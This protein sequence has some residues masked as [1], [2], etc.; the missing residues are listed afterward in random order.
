MNHSIKFTKRRRSILRFLADY[1]QD[2]GFPPSIREVCA[3]EEISSSSTVW[4]HLDALEKLKYIERD[5]SKPRSVSVTKSGFKALG[6]SGR[7]EEATAD[8]RQSLIECMDLLMVVCDL[9]EGTPE[10]ALFDRAV[11]A[12]GGPEAWNAAQEELARKREQAQ[13]V[14]C[15]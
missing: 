13:E 1:S 9:D 7:H 11:E 14:A 6:R 8:M 2:R 3:H 10:S 15:A 12:L 4:T 5:R